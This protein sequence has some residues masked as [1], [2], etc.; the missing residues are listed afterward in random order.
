MSTLASAALLIDAGNSRIK[1]A[2]LGTDGVLRGHGSVDTAA[3]RS[4]ASDLLSLLD[5]ARSDSLSR[6]IVSNVAGEAVQRA[7]DSALSTLSVEP[8]RSVQDCGGVRNHYQDPSQLGADRFA[9]LLGAHAI[10]DASGAD[11]LVVM[12]GTAL[13]IDALTS[14]GNFLGGSIAPGIRLMRESLARGTAQLPMVNE[15]E[16]AGFAR[17]TDSAIAQGTRDA[18]VGAVMQSLQ[19]LAA[20]VPSEIRIV[21]SGGAMP[22]VLP[23]IESALGHTLLSCP[24]KITMRPH[25]VLEGLAVFAALSAGVAVPKV[26]R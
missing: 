22:A 21:A 2:M 26:Q 7:I 18:A 1:W 16:E 25:L 5:A 11:K 12:A 9:A 17:D 8:F 23:A 3:A 15:A 10:G 19:R 20:R 4:N 6:V 14:E 24:V 13:T